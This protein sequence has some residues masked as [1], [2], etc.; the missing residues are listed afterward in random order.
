MTAQILEPGSV[1]G[2]LGGG[3]LGAMFA[4]AARRLGYRVAVWDPD[5]DAPAH[6]L[7]DDSFTA[8]FLDVE[9]RDRFSQ[10]VRAVTY[11]WENVPA[12]LCEWLELRHPVRP[13]GSVLRI[14]QDR[15]QQKQ[16]L[17]HHNLPVAPFAVIESP[18]QL[19]NA[20]KAIGLPALCKTARSGYD[21]KGQWLIQDPGDAAQVS[22]ELHAGTRSGQRWI[23][24]RVVAFERE[25]SVLVVSG[26]NGNCRTYPPVDNRHERGI[27]RLTL[28]P[29]SLPAETAANASHLAVQAVSALNSPGVFCV[30][31]FHTA[32]GNLF[33]NEIA[34]R[35]HNSGH[36]TLDAC[37]VSQFEQQV[38]V[39]CGAT[40]GEVQLLRPAAMVNLI[41]DEV[42]IV[43][44][45]SGYRD[46]M[47]IPGAVLH[48]YGKRTIRTGRKMGHVTFLAEEKT[49]AE[50]RALWLMKRLAEIPFSTLAGE[51]APVQRTE[52]P[53][54]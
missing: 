30:E 52:P 48:L 51:N 45:G 12:G 23:L 10:T 38:R 18:D 22:R 29:T 13:S 43:T 53:V 11:E 54:V 27:L 39:L 42:R 33:I 35:P 15:I 47:A 6:Q 36:Y 50:E 34:P 4:G 49:V 7:A 8:P 17:T 44:A 20:I 16:F 24:E 19:P 21:G 14:I 40:I 26:P 2:V 41:G 31:F 9:T 25:L 46:L 1:L 37:T 5:R 32:D 3:Q 28:A